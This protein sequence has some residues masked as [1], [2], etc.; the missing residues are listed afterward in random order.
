MSLV[1]SIIEVKT[2]LDRSELVEYSYKRRF[3]TIEPYPSITRLGVEFDGKSEFDIVVT[4][5]DIMFIAPE[6]LLNNIKDGII[7]RVLE[8]VDE[9]EDISI[10]L[11][12][13]GVDTFDKILERFKTGRYIISRLEWEENGRDLLYREMI[14]NVMANEVTRK[15]W[16][17]NSRPEITVAAFIQSREGNKH[18]VYNLTTEDIMADDWYIKRKID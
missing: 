12:V 15:T 4:E 13:L 7:K 11:K 6:S 1:K 5:R 10:T 14:D 17:I 18:G 3:G 16:G 2:F 9:C 8:L